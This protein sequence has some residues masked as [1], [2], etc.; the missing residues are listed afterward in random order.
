MISKK[1]IDEMIKCVK[2]ILKEEFKVYGLPDWSFYVIGFLK[3][4][5]SIGLI[6]SI[7][8]PEFLQPSA[9]GLAFLLV[10]SIAMHIK[11][12]DPIK[13]SFPALLFLLMCLGLAYAG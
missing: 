3:I 1:E 9:L 10:G 5:L 2:K 7:W 8:L 6:A 12:K 4:T 13:K 11:I